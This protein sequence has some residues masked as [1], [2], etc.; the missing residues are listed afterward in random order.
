MSYRV[1]IDVGGTFTDFLLMGGRGRTAAHKELSTPADPSEAVLRGLAL[2]AQG[3]ALSLERFLAEV[4]IIVHGTT[5]T[6]N[7]G[8]IR[9]NAACA[10]PECLANSP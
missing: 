6:T 8:S 9:H 3:E 1:G 7:A 4:A 2:L 5:V 10:R